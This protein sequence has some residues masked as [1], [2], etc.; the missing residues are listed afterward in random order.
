MIAV[1]SFQTFFT[2]ALCLAVTVVNDILLD[3]AFVMS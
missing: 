3:S 1:S 2:Q